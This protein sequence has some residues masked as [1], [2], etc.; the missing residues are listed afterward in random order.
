LTVTDLFVDRVGSIIEQ[1]EVA[2]AVGDAAAAQL[3]AA[4]DLEAQLGTDRPSEFGQ[5]PGRSWAQLLVVLLL[6][7]G[8]SLAPRPDESQAPRHPQRMRRDGRVPE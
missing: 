5:I 4:L 3:V 1:P 6:Y 2:T 7:A 8:Y